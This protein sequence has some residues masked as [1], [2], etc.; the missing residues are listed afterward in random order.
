MAV[1]FREGWNNFTCLKDGVTLKTKTQTN[2]ILM[3]SICQ[4][5]DQS[6]RFHL[7]MNAV[8]S[9]S[10]SIKSALVSN[11]PSGQQILVKHHITTYRKQ[12]WFQLH[13][14]VWSLL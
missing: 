8:L 6:E 4:L 13:N 10:I 3:S 7:L 14:A 12:L 11:L 2:N 9:Q 5:I 1:A